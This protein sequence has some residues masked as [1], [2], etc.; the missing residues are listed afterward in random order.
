MDKVYDFN[1]LVQEI[2]GCIILRLVTG[3][4]EMG[5]YQVSDILGPMFDIIKVRFANA[6]DLIKFV[7]HGMVR[8][9][10]ISDKKNIIDIPIRK[11]KLLFSN[12]NIL[13][14][15]DTKSVVLDDLDAFVVCDKKMLKEGYKIYPYKIKD[16]SFELESVMNIAFDFKNL[17]MQDTIDALNEINLI[18]YHMEGNGSNVKGA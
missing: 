13:G 8:F 2:D 11:L 15:E 1:W 5:I 16:A 6:N 7:N 17:G 9:R 4:N 14:E 12:S 18:N 3:G 10:D